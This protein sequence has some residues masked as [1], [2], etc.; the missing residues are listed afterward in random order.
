MFALGLTLSFAIFARRAGSWKALIAARYPDVRWVDGE[1]LAKWM[2]GPLQAELVL[3]DVR[4]AAEQ[5]VS[6]LRGA[7]YADP[8]NPDI[9]ALG[10]RSNATVVVYCSIGY[11]SAAIVDDLEQA[12]IAD[13]YNLEGGLF[14]WANE[15]RPIFRGSDQVHEVH[16][17]NRIWGLL[18]RKDLRASD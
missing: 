5:R 17:F 2:D 10:I 14:Q 18:L 7:Q 9:Q 6:H 8:D 13:I 11:R 15:G 12:G 4:T 16:P 1:T 3:V